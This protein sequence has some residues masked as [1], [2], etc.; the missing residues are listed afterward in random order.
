MLIKWTIWKKCI[1]IQPSKNEPGRYRKYEQINNHKYWNWNCDLKT[2]KTQKSKTGWLHRWILSNIQRRLNTNPNKILPKNYRGWKT[3]QAHSTRPPSPWYQ[4]QRK[5]NYRPL[6]RM[7]IDAKI[8][9]KILANCI[10]Q[11]IKRIIHHNQVGF[12]SGMQGFFNIC[13]LITWI[14]RRM[15][16]H[17]TEKSFNKTQYPFTIKKKKIL[18]KVGIKGTYLNII[19][20]IYDK[21]TANIIFN[22]EKL[23]AF[24]LRIGTIQGYPL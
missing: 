9:N 12:V 23:K 20:A 4:N 17:V 7:N 11:Y 22:S 15:K 6:S 3:C 21:P 14:N 19:K 10:Q 1:K 16:N 5:E 24:L 8:L 2:S 18:Q 13:I